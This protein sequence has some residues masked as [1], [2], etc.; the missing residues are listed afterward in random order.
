V[1]SLS[2]ARTIEPGGRDDGE[3]GRPPSLRR[4]ESIVGRDG[5]AFSLPVTVRLVIFVDMRQRSFG[6]AGSVPVIGQGT[7]KME[8]DDRGEAIAALRRGIDRGLTHIDT[9]EAY[10]DGKVESLVGEA[11]AGCRDALFLVSKVMPDHATYEGTLRACEKSLR[12]LGTD[13]LDCYLLHWPGR[14]PLAETIRAFETLEKAGKIRSWGLSNFDVDE[15]DEGRAIAGPGRVACNQVLDHLDERSVER[16]VL[17]W[18]AREGA[19]LVAYSPFGAGRFPTDRTARGRVLADVASAC[20][21]TPRQVALAFLVRH[22]SVLAIPKAARV[23]HVEEIAGAGDLVLPDDAVRRIEAAFPLP[24]AT[25]GL[26]M[27]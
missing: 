7:W 4:A 3:R 5:E 11:I 26:P 25:G 10:G 1:P 9:A 24:R 12:R 6:R 18:C 21:A 2:V 15:L 19:A 17:P 8:H 16:A 14:H 22:E 23:A 13:R 20:S 27:L